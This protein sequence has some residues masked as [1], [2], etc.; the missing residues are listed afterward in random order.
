LRRRRPTTN[1]RRVAHADALARAD[2][3]LAR[4]NEICG[5]VLTACWLHGGS[6]FADHSRA[7]ADVDVCVVVRDAVREQGTRLLMAAHE[8]DVDGLFVRAVDM[9]RTDWPTHAYNDRRPLVGWAVYRAHWLAGQFV[10]LHGREP[11]GWVVAPE[12]DDV[13]ADLDREVEHFERHVYEGDADDPYEATVAHLNGC[14]VLRTMATHDPVLSK[15]SA[16][17][18]GLAQLPDRWRPALEAALRAYDGNADP[19]DIALLRDSMPR[20]VSYVRER[21]PI[22]GP[23]PPGPPRWT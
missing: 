1:L 7:P 23:R 16:G 5:D 8:L 15:R 4:A 10:P 21:V 11:R 13:L 2:E 12:W 19:S 17:H 14:R 6:T 9:T 3:F 22:I 18:W 20:F